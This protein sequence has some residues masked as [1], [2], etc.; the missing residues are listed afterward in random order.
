MPM[1]P[2]EHSSMPA[3][4]TARSVATRSCVRVRRADLAVELVA[5]VEVVIHLVDAARRQ[6]L[7]LLGR[8]QP[9]AGAHLQVV[10]LLDLGHD[11]AR[12]PR[13]SRSFGPR[14][15]ITMQ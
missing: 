2:P 6:P 14:A 9:Q 3:S 8:E 1:M 13:I 5:R 7:G 11:R 10:L 12:P 15:E 4:R